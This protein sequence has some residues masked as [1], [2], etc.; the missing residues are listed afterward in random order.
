MHLG[1]ASDTSGASILLNG[2]DNWSDYVVSTTVDW[3]GGETVSLNGY[4]TD[5]NNYTH[6][7]FDRTA[8][9]VVDIDLDQFINGNQIQLAQGEVTE[10]SAFFAGD[11]SLGMTLNGAAMTC[12]LGTHTISSQGTGYTLNPPYKGPVGISV[13]DPQNG[14]AQ[15]VI[16]AISV[17]KV[18]N[19]Q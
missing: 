7:F 9:D 11:I 1:A 6:C 5:G 2:S 13:W 12:S 14:N 8:S 4:Y 17:E 10:T 18:V 15:I 16:K 19:P 3:V